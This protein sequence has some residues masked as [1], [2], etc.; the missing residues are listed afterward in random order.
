MNYKTKISICIP[1]YNRAKHL[2]NCLFSIISLSK[3]TKF[4]FEVCVSDNNSADNTFDVVKDASNYVDILYN[5]NSENIGIPKNFLKV[6]DMANGEYIWIIGDD[7]LLLNHSINKIN[8]LISNYN[9]VDF[10]YIN[11]KRY[12][13]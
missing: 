5:K 9:D 3:K 12:L 7:D 10:F 4:K 1:T 2:R 6:V 13:S 11:S 8:E